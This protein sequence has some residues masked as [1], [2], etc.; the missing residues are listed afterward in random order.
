MTHLHPNLSCKI[1]YL[2]QQL[3]STN[4]FPPTHFHQLH[5]HLLILA[6]ILIEHVNFFWTWVFKFT[7]ILMWSVQW[8]I[9]LWA[10]SCHQRKEV[11]FISRSS[12]LQTMCDMLACIFI[13]HKANRKWQIFCYLPVHY[14]MLKTHV[15]LS[16]KLVVLVL[17]WS[18][19]LI[20]RGHSVPGVL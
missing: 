15:S 18:H 14:G 6:I 9:F 7:Q 11:S 10:H 13:E 3:I 4:S 17:R 2:T 19:K 12:F 8:T 5:F 1:A 16:C 20:E